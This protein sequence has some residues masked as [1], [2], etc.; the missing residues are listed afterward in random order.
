M[1]KYRSR[2]YRKS[3]IGA[4]VTDSA[5]IAAKMTPQKAILWGFFSFG[6]LY[7]FIPWVLTAWLEYNKTKMNGLTGA[8]MGQM[9]DHVFIRRF[10]H[11]LE[12]AGIA[13]LVACLA[14]A[15]WKMLTDGGVSS[16]GTNNT[17]WV[18]RLVA[19]FLD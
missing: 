18:A 6:F 8:G 3:G 16:A 7:Y 4:M 13:C 14:I 9:L 11:P 1:S 12:W 15:A 17:S 2:R 5:A 10:I 19:R